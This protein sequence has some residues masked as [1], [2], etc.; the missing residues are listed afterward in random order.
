MFL[1]AFGLAV[2]SGCSNNEDVIPHHEELSGL[3]LVG[4]SEQIFRKDESG[5]DDG[6]HLTIYQFQQ[7]GI[8][9]IQE[10]ISNDAAW[11][12]LPLSDR[13]KE[14]FKKIV[15]PQND[16]FSSIENV[17]GYYKIVVAESPGDYYFLIYDS[18]KNQLVVI[19]YRN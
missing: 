2:L 17:E 6:V 8:A 4:Q 16:M 7:E 14:L 15:L 5:W 18:N 10:A 19:F 3:S 13:G 1:V 9:S 11:L 12:A